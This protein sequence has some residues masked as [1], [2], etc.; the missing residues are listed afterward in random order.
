MKPGE[1]A[2]KTQERESNETESI[3]WKIA[4][5]LIFAGIVAACQANA[6]ENR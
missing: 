6:E 2:N 5:M 1:L 4:A 3:V